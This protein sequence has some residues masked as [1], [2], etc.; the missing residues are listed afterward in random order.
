MTLSRQILLYGLLLTSFGALAQH[1]SPLQSAGN[2]HLT[3]A[4][5]PAT[6]KVFI[7]QLRSPSAAEYRASSQQ[8]KRFDKNSAAVQTYAAKITLEQDRVFN[9]AGPDAR[10]IY[11]YKYGLNG[12]AAR[13][14]IA[15]AQK[16]ETLPEVL[17]VWE[18]EIRPLATRY[19]ASFLGLFDR[20]SGLRSERELDGDGLVIAGHRYTAAREDEIGLKPGIE[21]R[22]RDNGQ[23]GDAD[24]G[25]RPFQRHRIAQ[26]RAPFRRDHQRM[27]QTGKPGGRKT[28]YCSCSRRESTPRSAAP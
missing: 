8:A 22:H 27:L 14:S 17:N 18:D 24:H 25:V 28:H 13:M 9:K 3:G 15:Q 21:D 12:F 23:Q 6:S 4:E 26:M 19:S 2:I 1:E 5:D 7:V 20:D 10:K 11:S 16:L